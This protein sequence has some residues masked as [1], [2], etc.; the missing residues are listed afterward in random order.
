MHNRKDISLHLYVRV[1]NVKK[2]Q[3]IANVAVSAL[4]VPKVTSAIE[5]PKWSK[6][7]EHDITTGT[8]ASTEQ[9]LVRY[10]D[11]H[12]NMHETAMLTTN[13]LSTSVRIMKHISQFAAVGSCAVFGQRSSK[14]RT[15]R[16]F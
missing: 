12:E 13:D 9:I 14:L 10:A 2:A 11:K 7:G 16:C 5:P 4:S 3:V 6:Y 15:S 8:E 1:S